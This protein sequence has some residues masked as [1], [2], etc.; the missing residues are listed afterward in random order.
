MIY[1][2]VPFCKSFCTYCGFY[3]EICSSEKTFLYYT[4]LVCEE[5]A[6]RRQEILATSKINTLY[7]GGGTPSVLPLSHI[8]RIV[9]A[10]P[11]DGQSYEEFTVEMNPDDVTVPLVAGLAALGA[12]RI[13]LGVQSFDDEILRRMARRHNADAAV[14]AVRAVREAGIR[15]LSIDLIFGFPSLSDEIWAS[16]IEKA[17][18]LHPE[19][20][21]CYQLSVEEGSAL[22]K[23]L[24]EGRWSEASQ[25][26]CR[27]QYDYLC[28]CLR[29]AGYNHY[30]VSN[31]ALPGYEAK[32]NSAYWSRA[33]YVGLGP[34]AHSFDGALVRRWNSEFGGKNK[35]YTLSEEKLSAYDVAVERLMLG[36]RTSAGLSA[37]EIEGII[38]P[39][40]TREAISEGLLETANR[41][42]G[43][44][45]LR[46][47]EEKFFVSDDII[48]TLI[49]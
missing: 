10:L 38:G 27:R 12:N 25:E 48:S 36:L 17:L 40:A 32:H 6:A 15:N 5:I 21:S 2:H 11:F 23:M 39:Q 26:Q 7:F 14:Q 24:Q 47:P 22:E 3:S 43:E 8:G 31:F 44:R 18:Q 4:D 20:I 42:S 34:G 49:P 9:E 13:S 30:E 46:I 37:A 41:H 1:I 29:Q 16:T 35:G 45:R 33:P 28:T 19:H